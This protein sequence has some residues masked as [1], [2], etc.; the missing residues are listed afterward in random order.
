MSRSRSHIATGLTKSHKRG[1][2]QTS[3]GDAERVKDTSRSA[4]I[5]IKVVDRDTVVELLSQLR[6]FLD[7]VLEEVNDRA[8]EAS[9]PGEQETL[10]W[11]D[12]G[13]LE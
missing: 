5:R 3:G 7:T 6:D 1:V 11:H 13:E 4:P 12:L 8:E 10:T 2:G 9:P